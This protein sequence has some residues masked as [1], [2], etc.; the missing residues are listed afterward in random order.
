MKYPLCSRSDMLARVMCNDILI[1]NDRCY[2][3]FIAKLSNPFRYRPVLTPA[4]SLSMTKK[5]MLITIPAVG[6]QL[7]E[8]GVRHIGVHVIVINV[9]Y[10]NIILTKYDEQ[11]DIVSNQMLGNVGIRLTKIKTIDVLVTTHAEVCPN[12]SCFSQA[13]SSKIISE[14]GRASSGES[15]ASCSLNDLS[16]TYTLVGSTTLSTRIHFSKTKTIRMSDQSEQAV[17]HTFCDARPRADRR[18]AQYSVR[19]FAPTAA[20]SWPCLGSKLTGKGLPK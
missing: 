18:L 1:H 11:I 15:T 9:S 6:A 2:D 19:Q 20:A 14:L 17:Y 4:L 7:F 8:H 12:L 13:T 10:I 16:K 3:I 5:T